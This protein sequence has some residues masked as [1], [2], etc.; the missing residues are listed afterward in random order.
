MTDYRLPNMSTVT[1]SF[2]SHAFGALEPHTLEA[3]RAVAVPRT[4]PP[5]TTL[6]HQGEIEH[7][8]YVVVSGNVVVSQTLEDG[9]ERIL[10]VIGARGYFGEMGLIDDAP[11]MANCIT[12]TDTAV[13]EVTEENFDRFMLESP[14][15]AY[16]VLRN[17][18]AT[19]RNID[20]Q[21]ITELQVKNEALQTAYADL[22]R[23]QARLVEKE[24]LVREL[25]LAADVQRSLLPD[26]LP[27]FPDYTF[28]AYLQPARQVGGDFYDVVALDDDHVGILIADVADKGFHAALFMAVTRTLFLQEGK[29]SLS[30]AAVATAVHHGMMAVSSHD[31]FLTA[32]YGVLHRPSGRL[33]YVR[34]AQERPLWVRPGREIEELPGNGRFLGMI[35]G[36]QLAEYEMQLQPGD[37]LVLFS[38]GVPDAINPAEEQFGLERLTAVVAA[39]ECLPIADLATHIAQ[40]LGEWMQDATPFDDLTLLVLERS[41]TSARS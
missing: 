13:L 9:Q 39:A 21:A 31:T 8:F 5:H 10:N 26:V 24:R 18:L 6:C 1:T 41:S 15:L 16:A 40:K 22:Q 12:L 32:F 29:H 33:T 38:D 30:P 34:A 36:L 7:T 2:I 20:Q 23:A 14:A 4:Y 28:A 25:E 19:T 35:D 37:R 27:Q 3:L 11:R 17:V